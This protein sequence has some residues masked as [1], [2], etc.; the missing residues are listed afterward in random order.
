MAPG[1]SYRHYFHCT[2]TRNYSSLGDATSAFN[3]NLR[4][5]RQEEAHP[6]PRAASPPPPQKDDQQPPYNHVRTQTHPQYVPTGPDDP[7]A[8]LDSG[9]MMTTIPTRLI[10][11]TPWERNIHP[12]QLYD[13]ATWKSSTSSGSH[14]RHLPSSARPGPTQ[15]SFNLHPR[16]HHPRPH[17]HLHRP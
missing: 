4:P 5:L 3:R 2:V 11:G 13:T 1:S 6:V 15:H 10:L 8:V 17:H 12:A 7:T 9:A 14:H 16:H